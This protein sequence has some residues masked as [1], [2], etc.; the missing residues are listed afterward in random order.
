MPRE[1]LKRRRTDVGLE[2]AWWVVRVGWGHRR[3]A[4]TRRDR[5]E[6]GGLGAGCEQRRDAGEDG[7][8]VAEHAAR[9]ANVNCAG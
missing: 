5:D 6:H 7:V 2:A 4:V 9:S 3:H 8:V 1:R